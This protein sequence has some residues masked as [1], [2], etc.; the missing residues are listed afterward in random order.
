MAHNLK[1]KTAVNISYNAIARGIVFILSSVA[2]IIL[3]RNLEASDYGVVGFALIITNFLSRF[4]DLGINSAMIQSANLNLQG[5]RTGF[6]IKITLGIFVFI[7]AY[8]VSPFSLYFLDHPATPTVIRILAMNFIISSFALLPQCV[9]TRDLN[10]KKLFIP[11][12]GSSIV[13]SVLSI[14]F[15]MTGFKYWAIVIAN[16][17]ST[18]TTTVLLNVIMPQKISLFIK[19]DIAK[20]YI[21]FGSNL[22]FAGLIVFMLF[23]A[24]N[25]IIGSVMGAT[26]L[27]FYAL[28]FNWGSMICS[29]LS[30]VVHNV[31]FPT[32][33]KIQK[34]RLNL[35][36]AYL[37]V[38]EYIS[39]LGVLVNLCLFTISK[40]FLYLILGHGTDKWLPALT[41]FKILCIYGIIRTLLEPAG[42]VIVALGHPNLLVRA[43]LIASTIEVSLLYPVLLYFGIEGVAILVTI[44]YATQYLIYFPS[45]FKLLKLRIG[46][47]MTSI[48]PAL[49]SLFSIIIVNSITEKVIPNTPWISLTGKVLISVLGYLI[50]YG[51]ITNWKIIIELR[52]LVHAI[53][54]QNVKS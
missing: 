33:A 17:A 31:L 30:E 51:M 32:F 50:L 41:S 1:I 38:L 2:S 27:G 15:A 37:K 43:N 12:V 42:N 20:D 22:F 6:T 49:I 11:Q 28:A 8:L 14:T 24:D 40:D 54:Y 9:L 26:M 34:D 36:F 10:Y 45:L 13:Y 48:G 29:L 23:N 39:F 44:A 3:A 21:K 5:L 47:V 25:F 52:T 53:L 35:K 19:K 7:L 16:V 4:S 18:L 46:E